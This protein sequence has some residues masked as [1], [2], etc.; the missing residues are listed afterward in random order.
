M[1]REDQKRFDREIARRKVRARKHRPN[2]A[3]DVEQRHLR[4]L[5]GRFLVFERMLDRVRTGRSRRLERR[6]GHA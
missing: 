6:V 3:P 5:I 1:Q 2:G 4:K